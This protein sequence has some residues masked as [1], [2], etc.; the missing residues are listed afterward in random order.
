M[1]QPIE[2]AKPAKKRPGVAHTAAQGITQSQ[3]QQFE[4]TFHVSHRNSMQIPQISFP[5]LQH[6][7]LFPNPGGQATRALTITGNATIHR[8]KRSVVKRIYSHLHFFN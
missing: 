4:F 5:S 1:P 7:Q 8:L 3:W 6:V 2:H